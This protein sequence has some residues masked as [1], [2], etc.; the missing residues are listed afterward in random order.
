MLM[1]QNIWRCDK[2]EAFTAEGD[3]TVDNM[4]FSKTVFWQDFVNKIEVG[5]TCIFHNL[6]ANQLYVN[7]A[8]KVRP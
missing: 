5:E 1:N 8:K 4:G 6:G 3:Q 7:T 2:G